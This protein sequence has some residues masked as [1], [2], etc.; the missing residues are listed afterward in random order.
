MINK[1]DDFWTLSG[2][3]SIIKAVNAANAGDANKLAKANNG[4][5]YAF[6]KIIEAKK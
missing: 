1:K 3:E 4:I 2:A 6:K 5:N